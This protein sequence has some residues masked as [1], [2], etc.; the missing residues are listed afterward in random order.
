MLVVQSYVKIY[1]M[2]FISDIVQ[3]GAPCSQTGGEQEKNTPLAGGGC[4]RSRGSAGVDPFLV[5]VLTQR[6]RWD[7]GQ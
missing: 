4:V 6:P 2:V 7:T 5:F 1:E 3:N